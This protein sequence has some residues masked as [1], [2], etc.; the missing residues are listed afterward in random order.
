[1]MI[2]EGSKDPMVNLCNAFRK[3]VV[4]QFQVQPKLGQRI[5]G[6]F[7]PEELRAFD[8]W[9]QEALAKSKVL[10]DQMQKHGRY[11][12]ETAAALDK[13]VLEMSEK[14]AECALRV[15]GQSEL[16]AF[17]RPQDR[18]QDMS[19]RYQQRNYPSLAK[20]FAP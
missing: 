1:M 13:I 4:A 11:D 6:A 19:R 3:A 20:I 14:S 18:S 12:E 9:S 2:W 8:A 17:V 16:Q 7:T 15:L 5:L 10:Q